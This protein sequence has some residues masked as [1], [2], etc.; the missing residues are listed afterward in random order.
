MDALID[1]WWRIYPASVLMALGAALAMVGLRN[2][3]DGLLRPVRD[4]EKVLTLIRGFRLAIIG[5]ALIGLGAAWLWGLAWLLILS[6]AIGGEE[7]L[8]SSI[9]IYALRY[10]RRQRQAH[11]VRS[12]ANSGLTH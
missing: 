6:L 4:P 3:L 12:G 5:L 2:E 7:T 8:E 1:P 10:G 9:V 11:L